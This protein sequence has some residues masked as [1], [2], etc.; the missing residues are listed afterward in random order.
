M[1]EARPGARS[2]SHR[3]DALRSVPEEGRLAL[4]PYLEGGGLVLYQ[5]DALAVLRELESESVDM[6]VTS[7]PF[8]G[9]RDYKTGRWEG[10][11]PDCPHR[12]SWKPR[13]ARPSG[14]LK[15]TAGTKMFGSE[16]RGHRDGIFRESCKRCGAVRIDEQVGLEKTPDEYLERLVGIFR[17]VRRVLR[18]AGVLLLEL[19]DSYASKA[20]GNAGQTGSGLSN[21][22]RQ[23][24]AQTTSRE[25]PW[26]PSFEGIK[27]KDLMGMPWALAFALRADGWW[28]RH[29]I[30]WEKPNPMP[31]SVEDRC[32][33]AHSF[34]F[35]LTKSHVYYWDAEA[36]REPAASEKSGNRERKHGA[37]VGAPNAHPGD[38][39]RSIPW[40]NDGHGRNARSVWTITTE[41]SGMGICPVCHTFWK[42]NAPERH[43][44]VEV[45][46]HFAAF[47]VA[48]AERAILAASS[49]RGACSSCG[50]PWERIL[51]KGEAELAAN[52]WSAEGG[53]Q[54]E[55]ET[56]GHVARSTLKHVRTN[57]TLGWKP[58]C[59]CDVD[60]TSPSIV[61]DCFA[62]SGSTLVAARKLGRRCIGIELNE[63]YCEM[64]GHRLKIP[65]VVERASETSVEPVQL[66]L[67]GSS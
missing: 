38:L 1:R 61:L 6:A 18:P 55:L 24:R 51:E 13:Q 50:R 34:V 56:N 28:L 2:A 49:A 5:G 37:D 35:H 33:T 45:V 41:P 47:P 42:R 12:P 20:A 54:Y 52:T 16:S 59:G 30:V 53:S 60:E 48:L 40:E 10:G 63:Q 31:E 23:R 58:T 14:K 19:G 27:E 66:L 29:C 15:S 11:D 17:E 25:K 22:A 64:A 57:R 4:T 67:G 26:R 8:F 46:C 36:I 43:C 7:P 9:L 65:D 44:G 32:T 62:G 3:P 39:G 21:P